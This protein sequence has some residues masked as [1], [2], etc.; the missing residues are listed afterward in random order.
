MQW[1]WV[2]LE[3]ST[4]EQMDGAAIETVAATGVS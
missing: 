3:E 4:A 2:L 1:S